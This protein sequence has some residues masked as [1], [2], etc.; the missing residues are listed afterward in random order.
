MY[1]KQHMIHHIW[2]GVLDWVNAFLTNVF[3]N[4]STME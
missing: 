2:M 3:V 4:M 1:D